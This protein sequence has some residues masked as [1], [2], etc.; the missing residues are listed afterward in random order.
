MEDDAI[1][2]DQALKE[3]RQSIFHVEKIVGVLLTATM[4]TCQIGREI[5]PPSPERW[6][7]G[8]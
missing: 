4:A 1:F 7:D 5:L 2:E 3:I 6:S 8:S